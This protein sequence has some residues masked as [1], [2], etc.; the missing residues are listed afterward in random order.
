MRSR[1]QGRAG[2]DPSVGNIV[3]VLLLQTYYPEFLDELYARE[4]R[5][6]EMDYGGQLARVFGEAFGIGDSYAAGLRALGCEAFE[7]ITN[8]DVAQMAWATEHGISLSDD[9]H[10]RRRQI[11]AAQVECLRVRV[12]SARRHVSLRNQVGRSA[13]GRADILAASR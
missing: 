7:V 2:A 9:R 12:V 10:E 8:A 1:Q 3:R 6:S 11:V 5:L 4:P 13:A